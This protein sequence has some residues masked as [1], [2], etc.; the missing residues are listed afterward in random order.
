MTLRANRGNHD[1]LRFVV[2]PLTLHIY[3]GDVLPLTIWD[4]E[5]SYLYIPDLDALR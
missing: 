1:I 4:L 5:I 3:V 2:L